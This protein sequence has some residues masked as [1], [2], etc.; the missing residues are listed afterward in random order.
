MMTK[1]QQ[2]MQTNEL[3]L[4]IKL[5]KSVIPH[6]HTSREVGFYTLPQGNE[7]GS[8]G[9]KVVLILQRSSLT[10]PWGITLR[11]PSSTH[12]NNYNNNASVGEPNKA[13]THGN[14]SSSSTSNIEGEGNFTFPVL[15]SIAPTLMLSDRAKNFLFDFR[16]KLQIVQVN[17]HVMR[18]ANDVRQLP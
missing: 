3:S 12:L 5:D 9:Q 6:L 16:D 7:G 14:G 18:T 2:S 8:V 13:N 15:S 1:L 11:L 10:V 17:H 4:S